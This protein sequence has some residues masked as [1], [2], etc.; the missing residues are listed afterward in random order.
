VD[1]NL[2]L[3]VIAAGAADHDGRPYFWPMA[4]LIGFILTEGEPVG[5]DDN[6]PAVAAIQAQPELA[7]QRAAE[8]DAEV[9][10]SNARAEAHHAAYLARHA[11]K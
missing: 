10:A 8:I 7:R 4:E 3:A 11:A 1:L 6:E 2:A 9:A 5:P